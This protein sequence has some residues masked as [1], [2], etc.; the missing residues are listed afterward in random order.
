MMLHTSTWL[1][2]HSP[3]PTHFVSTQ[4][5]HIRLMFLFMT[6]APVPKRAAAGTNRPPLTQFSP[7]HLRI[8]VTVVSCSSLQT[9]T[10]SRCRIT[11]SLA[12]PPPCNEGSGTPLDISHA[13]SGSPL[14]SRG[15]RPPPPPPR[16]ASDIERGAARVPSVLAV[17]RSP[18]LSPSVFV[19]GMRC[20]AQILWLE[21]KRTVSAG[22]GRGSARSDVG[23][24][25][26]Q[27][28]RPWLGRRFG[29]SGALVWACASRSLLAEMDQGERRRRRRLSTVP[30]L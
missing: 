25:G 2:W 24:I 20:D 1:Y 12:L 29:A 6:F 3:F 10:L 8:L 9:T 16:T 13:P 28:V 5:C 23:P 26:L 15:I 17:C 4:Y 18:P 11:W 19:R 7:D 22:A 30:D 21:G 27:S 14:A